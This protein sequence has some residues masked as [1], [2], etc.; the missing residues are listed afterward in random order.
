[1][2]LMFTIPFL[3]AALPAVAERQSFPP[4]DEASRDP[5]LVAFRDQLLAVVKTR[6]T[7]AVLSA[8]CPEIYLSHG[9]DGGHE[10]F[11]QFLTVPPEML[12][13]DYRDQ[14]EEMREEYWSALEKT[15]SS[16]GYFDD[17]GEFW[18]PHQW[19]IRLPA[20]IDPFS[21]YFVDGTRVSLRAAPDPNAKVLDLISH[22]V[23]WID[24]FA[25]DTEY[26]GVILTD[27]TR[28]YMHSDFLW[29]MVGYR[30]A[31]VKSEAGDWQLCTFVAGD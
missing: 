23:V 13:E 19:R 29:S 1:M 27:G 10:E 8:A 21:T 15:L 17:E 26:Q 6:N 9:G 5:S 7:E 28:G 25:E 24:Q 4:V 20:D 31:F 11:R 30:A 18:M 3:F 14:A 16:A 22:E 12:G 2:K